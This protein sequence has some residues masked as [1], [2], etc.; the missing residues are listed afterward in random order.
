MP[1]GY[2]PEKMPPFQTQH[3]QLKK[4]DQIYMFSD[5]YADQFGGPDGKKF[6]SATFRNLLLETSLLTMTE[7]K[8]K[9]NETIINWMG[10]NEQID[11]MLVIGI[12]I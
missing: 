1:V 10:I 12:R 6:K 9:L 7:Q 2:H 11:D 8:E 5:G 4:G 3:I